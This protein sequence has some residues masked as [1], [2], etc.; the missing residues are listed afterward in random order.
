MEFNEIDSRWMN[1][2]SFDWNLNKTIHPL[3]SS[4]P[5]SSF[6]YAVQFNSFPNKH[7]FA[8][9]LINHDLLKGSFQEA[10]L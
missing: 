10:I 5:T 8:V 3:P 7:E 1:Q 9:F 2:V 4:R 6:P